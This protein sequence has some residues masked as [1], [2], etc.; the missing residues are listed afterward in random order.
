MNNLLNIDGWIVFGFFAQF[1]FMSRF[2]VQWLYSEYHKRSVTPIYFWYLSLFGS[3]AIMLY[4]YHIRDP[5]FFFGQLVV[6]LIYIRNIILM[7]NES[8][9]G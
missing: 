9:Q 2:V 3:A 7:R 4:S 6:F 8:V 1:L 5:V